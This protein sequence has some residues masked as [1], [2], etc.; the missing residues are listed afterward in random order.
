MYD[1]YGTCGQIGVMKG[2]YDQIM[3]NRGKYKFKCG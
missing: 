1:E 3:V 2:K